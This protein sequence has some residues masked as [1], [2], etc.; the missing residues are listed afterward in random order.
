MAW[1]AATHLT[2]FGW[3]WSVN[4]QTGN[5]A[6][7]WDRVNRIRRNFRQS[8]RN[9]PPE[10]SMSA[11]VCTRQPRIM[12]SRSATTGMMPESE[13]TRRQIKVR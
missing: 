9:H 13:Q 12:P 1:C 2:R 4:R 3:F 5:Y 8:T 10:P 6:G 11:K 7:L